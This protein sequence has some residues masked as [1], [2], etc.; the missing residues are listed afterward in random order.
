V[1]QVPRRAGAA[2]EDVL[3]AQRREDVERSLSGR[4]W[5]RFH[6]AVIVAG[7]F[8][9]GF[10]A[11]FAM[12]GVGLTAL[13]PRWLCA[14][15]IA[16]GGFFLLVRF[17][18]AYVGVRQLAIGPDGAQGSSTSSG[19]IDGPLPELPWRGGGGRFGGAGATGDFA[20]PR[21]ASLAELAPAKS[22]STVSKGVVAL[23]DGA[24]DVLPLVLG[25]VVLALVAALVGSALAFVWVAPELLS[26]AAFAAL[27]AS[28]MLPGIGRAESGDWHGRLFAAT[29]KPLVGVVVV[30][31]GAALAL[32]RW[33][34]G[35]QTLGQAWKML[36]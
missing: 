34:P 2:A 17:W 33:F 3:R 7:T 20:P 14:I 35:A 5:L 19:G 12:L 24:D 23:A 31:T 11:N 25:L 27:L 10:L 16:Y 26:D 29:W 4:F 30:A 28:G 22:S 8:A 21:A 1:T 15:A 32:M 36:G 6:A 18:L 9:T 13:L